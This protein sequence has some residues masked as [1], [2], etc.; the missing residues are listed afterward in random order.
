MSTMSTQHASAVGMIWV[1]D[2]IPWVRCA[3]GN[4]CFNVRYVM[5]INKGQIWHKYVIKDLRDMKVMKVMKVIKNIARGTTDPGYWVHNSNHSQWQITFWLREIRGYKKNK[6]YYFLSFVKILKSN[7]VRDERGQTMS[8]QHASAVGMIWVMD[9][10]PWV[11]CASGN[12]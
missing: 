2:S 9:S 5:N 12:V 6:K 11:R 8:T 1:M 7:Y 3:S 4:V 10:I